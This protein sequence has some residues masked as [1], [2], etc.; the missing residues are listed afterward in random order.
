MGTRNVSSK[1]NPCLVWADVD[2]NRNVTGYGLNFPERSVAAALNYCRNPT[3]GAPGV[4]CYI[5]GENVSII[6]EKC[7]VPMCGKY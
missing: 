4:F 3:R 7:D 2:P 6:A 5:A 1:G